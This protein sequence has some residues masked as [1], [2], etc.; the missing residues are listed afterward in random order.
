LKLKPTDERCGGEVR[1]TQKLSVGKP[2]G[3]EGI[4]GR[5]ILK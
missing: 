5:I 4:N 3:R 2:D 1:N